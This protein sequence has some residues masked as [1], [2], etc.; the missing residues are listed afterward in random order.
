MTKKFI[1]DF[2][3]AIQGG[4]NLD[5]WGGVETVKQ[6]NADESYFIKDTIKELSKRGK[7]FQGRIDVY[8]TIREVMN[9]L[10]EY[11]AYVGMFT[12][13]SVDQEQT[14]EVQAAY[15]EYI[16]TLY[17]LLKEVY[18][19]G[20]DCIIYVENVLWGYNHKRQE[21]KPKDHDYTYYK[22]LTE[23][24]QELDNIVIDN[25]PPYMKRAIEDGAFD[26]S[27]KTLK[28][29]LEKY[30]NDA[31]G[32]YVIHI[33]KT[34]QKELY[35]TVYDLHGYELDNLLNANI[36]SL[37]LNDLCYRH[38]FMYTENN[39]LTGFYG[40]TYNFMRELKG[41]YC[42]KSIDTHYNDMKKLIKELQS[43]TSK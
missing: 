7:D 39:D 41:E 38:L 18:N 6:L 29:M 35:K 11:S 12:L 21:P 22:E 42:Y 32:Q 4:D 8:N 13:L 37:A 26:N 5:E 40:S 33:V 10:S 25:I 14:K 1:Q 15:N 31:N 17:N 27:K 2:N 23:F 19:N 36:E 3:N 9:T 34:N 20:N 30:F 43:K 16:N 24:E 28:L